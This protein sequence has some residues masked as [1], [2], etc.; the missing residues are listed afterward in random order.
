MTDKYSVLEMGTIDVPVGGAYTID[1]ISNAAINMW[2][3]VVGVAEASI[4]NGLPRVTSTTTLNDPLLIGLVVE[5]V[6]QGGTGGQAASAAGLAVKVC[7]YGRCKMT[8]LAT[9]TNIAI[10]DALTSSTT[11]GSGQKSPNNPST[12]DSTAR[13]NIIAYALQPS[14]VDGDVIAVLVTR[15]G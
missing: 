14:I 3:P 7:I 2:A 1:A 15:N 13:R 10:M 5:G 12:Y 9:A 8:V 6:T 4:T 11:S